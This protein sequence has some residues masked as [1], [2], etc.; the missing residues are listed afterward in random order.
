[1]SAMCPVRTT[2]KGYPHPPLYPRGVYIYPKTVQIISSERQKE[3]PQP[4]KNKWLDC[5]NQQGIQIGLF[6]TNTAP[7]YHMARNYLPKKPV[8]YWNLL[9]KFS[10]GPKCCPLRR[11]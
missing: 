3:N 6:H 7:L 4:D 1:M 8:F 9:E 10:S 11:A 5:N 2:T